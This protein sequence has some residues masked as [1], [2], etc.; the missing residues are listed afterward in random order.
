MLSLIPDSNSLVIGGALRVYVVATPLSS[1]TGGLSFTIANE[2]TALRLDSIATYCSASVLR[3]RD[4]ATFDISL[5]GPLPNDTIAVVYY[6]TMFGY[7]DTPSIRL[8]NLSTANTCDSVRG[9]GGIVVSLTLPG[10]DLGRAILTQNISGINRIYPNPNNGTAIV[11]YSTVEHADVT[12]QLYD[13]LGR[14]LKAIMD[15]EQQPGA[16]TVEFSLND[17]PAGVYFLS[18]QEGEYYEMKV[19]VKQ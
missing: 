4:S 8:Q 11:E 1:V 12:L 18:L 7:T 3:Q 17:L 16:Y 19:L 13:V 14:K 15:G 5:C 2:T 10:C 9:T 6:Q